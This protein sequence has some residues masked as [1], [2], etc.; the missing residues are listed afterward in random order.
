MSN[1]RVGFIGLGSMGGDQADCLAAGDFALTVYDV[2]P[3]SLERFRDKANIASSIADVGKNADIVGICVRD[4]KQV[5]ETLLGPEGLLENMAEGSVVLIHSTV[6]PETVAYLIDQAAS[7][8]IEVLDA[9]VSRTRQQDAKKGEPFVAVMLGGSE[10][11]VARVMPVLNAYATNV[12]HAGPPGSGVKMK[13]VNNMISWTHIVT[14]VQALRLAKAS[15]VDVNVL[16]DLLSNN[17]N[18]TKNTQALSAT[19]NIPASDN[20]AIMEYMESQAG[21]GEKDLQLAMDLAKEVGVSVAIAEGVQ[22]LVRN[23]MT[24]K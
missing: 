12:F 9:A 11:S 6:N 7:R 4:D 10:E 14:F 1:V 13:I 2:Y 22:P 18:L 17:G 15:N 19:L 3:P 21:I 20:P 16:L 5:K 23:A 24:G 8:K